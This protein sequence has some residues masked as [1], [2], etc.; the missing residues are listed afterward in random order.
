MAR[1]GAGG[2]GGDAGAAGGLLSRE[3]S[4]TGGAVGGW[5]VLLRRNRLIAIFAG[6]SALGLVA[7]LLVGRFVV[8]P[9][10]SASA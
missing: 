6:A 5:R 8:S 3:A 2:A 1:D 4:A 9:A 10:D 7:G